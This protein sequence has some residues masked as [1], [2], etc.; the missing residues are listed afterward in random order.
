MGRGQLSKKTQMERALALA[1]KIT[2]VD[3]SVLNKELEESY[4]DKMAEAEA[5][6]TYHRLGGR[7][8]THKKCVEC[9]ELFAY[10]WDRDSISRCSVNCM[11]RGLEKIGLKWDPNRDLKLRWGRT[12]P[13]VVPPSALQCLTDILEVED[14]S[15]QAD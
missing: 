14:S 2:G 3:P 8:F 10:S 15:S 5:V 7:N 6:L 13:M 1:A 11:A 9:G 12:A 4:E